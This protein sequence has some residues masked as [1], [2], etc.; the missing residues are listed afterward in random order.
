MFKGDWDKMT[1]TEH[2]SYRYNVKLFG[3]KNVGVM[4]HSSVNKIFK[5]DIKDMLEEY[6]D[7]MIV[8]SS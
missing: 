6:M 3:L 1:L 4:S 5:D 7:N 2:A 8:K